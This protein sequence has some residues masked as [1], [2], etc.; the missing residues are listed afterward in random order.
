MAQM[1]MCVENPLNLNDEDWTILCTS[2]KLVEK[3]SKFITSV[4]FGKLVQVNFEC[5]CGGTKH[6]KR[7]NKAKSKIETMEAA[8]QE[9]SKDVSPI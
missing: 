2:N 4:K 9:V 7:I 8:I 5:S 3:A 6:T 1:A